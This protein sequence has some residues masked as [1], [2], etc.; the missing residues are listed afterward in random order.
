[1]LV[2]REGIGH[3][4]LLRGSD[5]Q[6]APK[7]R[8]MRAFEAPARTLGDLSADMAGRLIAAAADVALIVD[9]KGVIR[10]MAF[11]SDDLL[12]ENYHEW[13]GKSW[14]DT[15]TIESRPKVEALLRDSRAN[16]APRGPSAVVFRHRAAAAGGSRQGRCAL[17]RVRP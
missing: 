16:A 17:G 14:A 3:D 6:A 15:V 1:M 12:R 11:G 7:A 8:P 13:L 4:P 10:D 2:A 5:A 9:D